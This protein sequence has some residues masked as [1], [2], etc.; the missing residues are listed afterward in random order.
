[1]RRLLFNIVCLDNLELRLQKGIHLCSNGAMSL[2]RASTLL[3]IILT[4][5]VIRFF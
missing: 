5:A 1:M 4:I 3:Q 2:K